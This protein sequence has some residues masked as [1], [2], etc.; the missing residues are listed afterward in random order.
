MKEDGRL[1]W[2]ELV[3]WRNRVNVIGDN[4][5]TNPAIFLLTDPIR[6]N[7]YI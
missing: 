5:K 4:N 3:K 1:A 2:L 6:F 7:L